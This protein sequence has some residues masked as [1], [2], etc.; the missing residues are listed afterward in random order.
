LL[1]LQQHRSCRHCSRQQQQQLL[2]GVILQ[3]VM[4]GELAWS[5]TCAGT[6]TCSNYS[7]CQGL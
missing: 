2:V 6:R 1:A 7:R 5:I 4:L 3:G